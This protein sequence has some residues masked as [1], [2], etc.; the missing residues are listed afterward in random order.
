MAWH[1][2]W[3]DTKWRFLAGLGVLALLAF[4]TVISYPRVAKELLPLVK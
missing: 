2:A 3:L 1:K 4:G